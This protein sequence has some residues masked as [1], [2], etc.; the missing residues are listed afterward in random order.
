MRGSTSSRGAAPGALRDAASG[1][2]TLC[3]AGIADD[4]PRFEA[5]AGA[6]YEAAL[7]L[8]PAHVSAAQNLSAIRHSA[9]ATAVARALYRRVLAAE[10][11]HA[12]P[13]Y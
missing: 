6:A 3:A 13:T 11:L 5:D 1:R 2:G 10:Q 9:G 4:A 8:V 12:L 7:A